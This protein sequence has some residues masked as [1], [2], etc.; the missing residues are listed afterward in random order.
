MLS[1]A[2]RDN[3]RR[4]L[5]ALIPALLA[6]LLT[7][8]HSQGWLDRLDNRFFDEVTRREPGRPPRVVLIALDPALA[9]QGGAGVA[10]LTRAALAGGMERIVFASDPGLAR[11]PSGRVVIG[12]RASQ[13]PA[14]G[15]W[16][17][18]ARAVPG[19]IMAANVQLAAQAGLTRR[20]LTHRGA[21][22]ALETAATRRRI[23]PGTYLVRLSQQQ[24]LPRITAAQ[25]M[26][27]AADPGML[28]GLIGLVAPP[29]AL[30]PSGVYTA[31]DGGRQLLSRSAFTAAAIQTLADRRE[32]RALPVPAV[33]ALLLIVAL[34]LALVLVRS[35]PKRIF[36]PT[37]VLGL[38]A[39][40]GASWLA[41][42]YLNLLLPI[43][44]LCL[45]I[46]ATLPW[47]LYRHE[48]AEDV[49]L[50]RFVVR[51]LNRSNRATLMKD[52][53]SLP[54]FLAASASRLGIA[55]M[56]VVE[57]SGRSRLGELATTGAAL[58]EISGNRRAL[59]R[60]LA[61]ARSSERD[62]D[63]AALVPD[64]PN[65]ARLSSLGGASPQL[66]WL[67]DLPAEPR[68]QA[69]ANAATM[70]AASYRHMQNLREELGAGTTTTRGYRPIDE[71]AG[72]AVELI[73]SRAEHLGVGL[74]Q[75]NTAVMVFHP[76]GFPLHANAQMNALYELVGL[77]LADAGLAELVAAL[78][79]LESDRIEAMLRDIQLGGG[80]A[81]I[82]CRELDGRT[83]LLRVASSLQHDPDLPQAL[84]A[85]VIDVTELRRLS[86]L[87][88]AVVNVLDSQLRNDL[89]AI[90]LAASIARDE[91]LDRARLTKVIARIEQATDRAIAR[92][93]EVSRR[94]RDVR[95]F[96]IDEAYPIQ[97]AELVGEACAMVEATIREFGV[98]LAVNAPGISSF[99]IAEP[100]TLVEM[101]DAILRIMVADTPA[102]ETISVDL[103]ETEAN[104]RITISG[105][106]GIAFERFYAALDSTVEGAPAP[107]RA[108]TRGM[109]AAMSWGANVSYS[110]G[111]G[112]GYRFIIDLRRIG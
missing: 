12:A 104:T 11:V 79:P 7:L 42:Q 14:T 21:I 40:L 50:R 36:L 39:A 110:S 46:L 10:S 20:Q 71:W 1:G 23:V 61:A 80:E 24:N 93:E 4:A 99:A 112:R 87:N 111:V 56:L 68:T 65:N 48:R 90:T 108:I 97:V 73:A 3:W 19:A 75:L 85:E 77:A 41:L 83:R 44:A 94:T 31:R 27:G 54:G 38:A 5:A 102:G 86:E 96:A 72:S 67:H 15:Q 58:D 82:H 107:F 22:P 37:L 28:K 49:R 33:S 95:G 81:K 47:A 26:S 51:T 8:A 69:A 91:R 13:L 35:D 30:A 18:N 84:V 70:I 89:A 17:L 2:W 100:N 105:G 101:I 53:A 103:V 59:R 109:S 57:R 88:L 52:T 60:A 55:R 34:L 64:W 9:A 25:L 78:T 62:I 92:M 43:G 16:Q 76:I 45:L 74:D 98:D 32:V 106:M 63:A 29:A 6:G 66:Y